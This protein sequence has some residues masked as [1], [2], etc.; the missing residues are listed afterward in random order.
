MHTDDSCITFS[1]GG[2]THCGD[3]ITLYRAR[4]I[5]KGLQA[6]KIGLRLN[7]SYTPTKLFKAATSIT[8]QDYKRGQYDVV[9][10][11]LSDWIHAAEAAM[12]VVIED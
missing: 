10:Q 3:A 2:V 8:G 7:R 11:S 6:C 4:V 12:P 1:H 9:I 5:R